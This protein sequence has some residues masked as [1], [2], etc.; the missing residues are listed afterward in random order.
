MKKE[1]KIFFEIGHDQDADIQNL[2][3][4]NNLNFVGFARDL[5][6]I[7]RVAICN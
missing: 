2:I 6:G 3:E 1:A 5:A 4:K 7:N